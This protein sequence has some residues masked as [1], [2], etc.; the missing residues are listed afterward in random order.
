MPITLENDPNGE[1]AAIPDRC[2]D[3]DAYLKA[4]QQQDQW[5]QR[6]S[7]YSLSVLGQTRSY[8][9]TIGVLREVIR[10]DWD[11]LA[12]RDQERLLGLTPE[13]QGWSLLGRMWHSARGTVFENPN[14]RK[15]EAAVRTVVEAPDND[16]FRSVVIAAYREMRLIPGVDRGVASRLLTL[17]R[18]DRCVSVNGGSEC[19]LAAAFG[20]KPT[21]LGETKNYKR[22]LGCLY[23]RDWFQ[24]PEPE[25]PFERE[26]WSMRAALID[27]FVYRPE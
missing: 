10:R 21:T 26:I 3:W 6:E 12:E 5:F 24:A 14:R 8:R 2:A 13:A 16:D 19:G 25:D 27:C 4:L 11:T 22:L 7:N 17:A 15:I 18:P 9:Q 20:L 23:K 1:R